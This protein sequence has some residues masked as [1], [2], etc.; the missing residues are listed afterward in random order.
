MH[1][2]V[3]MQEHW[4]NITLEHAGITENNSTQLFCLFVCFLCVFL[5]ET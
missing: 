5:L 4:E 3:E 1:L 2:R